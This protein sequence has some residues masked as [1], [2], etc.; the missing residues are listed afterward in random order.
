MLFRSDSLKKDTTK[1]N[2]NPQISKSLL[3]DS[4]QRNVLHMEKDT[5]KANMN[6][7]ISKPVI[8][9]SLQGN[10]P[11]LE[12]DTVS[13]VPIPPRGILEKG[14]KEKTILNP[15]IQD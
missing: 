8:P 15:R 5:T 11:R 9:D 10:G 3:P 12:K 14:R 1:V 6:P 7:Q 13:Q 4:L 2:I